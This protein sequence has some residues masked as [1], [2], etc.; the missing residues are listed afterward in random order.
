MQRR[1][2][3]YSTALSTAAIASAPLIKI[4]GKNVT[5]KTALIGSGWW[6]TNIL[7]YAIKSKQCKIVALCDV[8]I[9]QT[10]KTSQ[11]V[12]KLSGETPGVYQDYRQLLLKE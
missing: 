3:L 2:F 12:K 10:Y 5:Y 7:R 6:G 11:E 8:D 1:K 9:N 4:Y